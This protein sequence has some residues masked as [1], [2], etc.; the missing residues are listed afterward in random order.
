[1]VRSRE[2]EKEVQ[3]FDILNTETVADKLYTTCRIST[4][5]S[6]LTPTFIPVEL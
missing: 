4:A 1:M 3:N 5:F 2:P 6:P